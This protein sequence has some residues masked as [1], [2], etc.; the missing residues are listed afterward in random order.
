MNN[1]AA[2]DRH[3]NMRKELLASTTATHIYCDASFKNDIMISGILV[4]GPGHDKSICKRI[5]NHRNNV[6]SAE[7]EAIEMALKYAKE[8]HLKETI[9]H[10][11][12]D[13]VL[14]AYPFL[15]VL[16]KYK[17]QSI[18]KEHRQIANEHQP[19]WKHF[20]YIHQK[21]YKIIINK[22]RS[23]DNPAHSIVCKERDRIIEKEKYSNPLKWWA[24]KTG[25]YLIKW[26]NS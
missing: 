8:N 24:I 20:R 5:K 10:T 18:P 6:I 2:M 16:G 12:I 11:E 15:V 22:V 4:I 25:S 17:I 9:I 14:H 1:I 13:S 21:C 19:F 7:I 3:L 26:G 23:V